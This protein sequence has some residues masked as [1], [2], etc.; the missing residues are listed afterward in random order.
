MQRSLPL[1]F[2]LLPLL[3]TALLFT[4]CGSKSR[5][6]RGQFDPYTVNGIT[7]YPLKD[8][9]GYRAQGTASYYAEAF[10]G[11]KTASGERYNQKELTCAH[12]TLPF[13]TKV[14][15]T[16]LHNGRSVLVRVNDR[17]PFKKGRIVDLS[18]AAAREL[19]MLDRGTARVL[20]EYADESPQSP[21]EATSTFAIQV[22]AFAEKK[23]AERLA[24]KLRQMGY[25]PNLVPNKG[26]LWHVQIGPLANL[27]EAEITLALLKMIAGQAYLISQ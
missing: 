6:H 21:A 25:R 26:S 15:V 5:P 1:T 27:Q 18:K 17:G 23:N 10:Q 13:A 16:N 11:R 2:L 22:G 20:V 14:R 7:Y 19:K 4:G 12:T 3:L 24:Q 8:A 9:R